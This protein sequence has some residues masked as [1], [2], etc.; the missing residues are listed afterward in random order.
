MREDGIRAANSG[1]S[2]MHDIPTLIHDYGVLVVFAAVLV[3]G[4]GVPV[5]SFAVV[6][7][8]ASVLDHAHLGSIFLAAFIAG[9]LTDLAWY[10]AGHRLGYKL[11][12]TLCRV[13]LSTDSCV[14]RTESVFL[15]W[16]LS[17]LLVARF[18]PGYS[19]VAQPLAGALRQ[20]FVPFLFYDLVGMVVWCVAGIVLGAVFSSAVGD[21]LNFLDRFGTYG[22]LAL[23][24]AFFAYIAYRWYRRQAV[25]KQLRMDRISAIELR[26]LIQEGSQ[27]VILDIRPDGARAREGI[28]PGSIYVNPMAIEKLETTILSAHEIVIYCACPNEASAAH[29]A[30]RLMTRGVKRVRPLLGGIDA[31][32]DAGFEVHAHS[33]SSTTTEVTVQPL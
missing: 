28:I 8:A 27:P 17:S 1:V 31:W 22:T 29:I 9:L 23:L 10:W 30:Q 26:R 3:E 20:P 19:L 7:L 16:G 5:P 14:Q 24:F 18:L 13:S 15:R 12:R 6:V 33:E 11:L 32:T 2:D 21:V 4:I 25:I